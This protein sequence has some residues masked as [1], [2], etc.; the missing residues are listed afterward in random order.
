M[1]T[2]IFIVLLN[3]A[4]SLMLAVTFAV[5]WL[6]PKA[7]PY[8]AA[9]AAGHVAVGLGFLL[10][11]VQLP[12]GF[13]PTKF[14]SNVFL[15]CGSVL[16]ASAVIARAGRPVPFVPLLGLAG[17][18]L[19]GFLWFTLQQPFLAGRILSTCLAMGGMGLIVSWNLYR[20]KNKTVIDKLLLGLSLFIAVNM[21]TVTPV[22]LATTG[23]YISYDGYYQSTFWTSTMLTHAVQAVLISICLII[24]A[25]T[26]TLESLRREAHTDPLSGLLNRRGFEERALPLV[27]QA[28]TAGTPLCLILADL[29]H[30]KRVNDL[31]GHGVGDSVIVAFSRLI[32][33]NGEAGAVVGRTGGEEFALLMPGRDVSVV[34]LFAE[35]LRVSVCQARLAGVPEAV[36]TVS[37]SFGVAGLLPHEDLS[38]LFRRADEALYE[39]KR[40][41]RNRVKV[42]PPVA[43]QPK[44]VVLPRDKAIDAA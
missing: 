14:I 17:A 1:H 29:D 33:E 32:G 8:L 9:L 7:R 38:D 25:T 23:R 36:G 20:H 35:G 4:L 16:M 2:S 13:Y 44:A 31:Y 11:Y 39:A 42:A 18:G 12:I 15:M 22:L 30:F 10:Q 40:D 19:C 43:A 26:E 28:R 41:G 3:P 6:Q 21:V 24:G 27:R 5:L 37:A 34:R